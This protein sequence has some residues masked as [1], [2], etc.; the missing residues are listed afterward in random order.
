MLR[1]RA[2]VFPS[3]A[4]EN[5]PVVL[6]EAMSAGLPVIA[7]GSGAIPEVFAGS[8]D[9]RLVAA[10]DREAWAAALFELSEG[11]FLASAG[12]SMRALYEESYTP[13]TSKA[14][15]ET[16]YQNVIQQRRR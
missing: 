2:L 9:A 5:Q 6:L 4:Y 7:S 3:L 10:G 16:V 12:A 11:R 14:A 13:D 8:P 1:S 15:L